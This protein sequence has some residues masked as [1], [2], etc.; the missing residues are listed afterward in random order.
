MSEFVGSCN[1]FLNSGRRNQLSPSDQTLL[2]SKTDLSRCCI[3][4]CQPKIVN[5]STIEP[6][7]PRH[8]RRGPDDVPLFSMCVP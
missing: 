8:G 1:G 7:M 3:L 5:A 4:P 6:D 2:V